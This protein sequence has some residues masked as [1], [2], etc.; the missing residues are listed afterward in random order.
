MGKGARK[1]KRAKKTVT[2]TRTTLGAYIPTSGMP[3]ET[4][5]LA[6][7]KRDQRIAAARRH[8]DAVVGQAK[9]E[10]RAEVTSG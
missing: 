6:Q 2:T 5:R 9:A 10:Y 1:L 7:K 4:V 8:F 3:K